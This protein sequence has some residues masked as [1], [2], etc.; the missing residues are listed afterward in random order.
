MQ[1]AH[2]IQFMR[3]V[4]STAPFLTLAPSM[5]TGRT[6]Q[7]DFRYKHTRVGKIS[8]QI[9]MP[10]PAYNFYDLPLNEIGCCCVYRAQ[11]ATGAP[12]P[13]IQSIIEIQ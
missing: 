8:L 1:I 2:F 13:I 3:G 9:R 11:V 7:M 12:K 6:F 10:M 5:H 4:V